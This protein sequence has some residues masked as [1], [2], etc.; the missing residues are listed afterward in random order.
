MFTGFASGAFFALFA[1]A[2]LAQST[3]RIDVT[4]TETGIVV[5]VSDVSL[6]QVLTEMQ[7]KLG[8]QFRQV[9]DLSVHVTAHAEG[10]KL[11]EVLSQLLQNRASFFLKAASQ[12]EKLED[13]EYV[14]VMGA[15]PAATGGQR[16]SGPVVITLDGPSNPPDSVEARMAS[17]KAAV[18]KART[19]KD[20]E[21]IDALSA[22]A[23]SSLQ[24][25]FQQF[26]A[27]RNAQLYSRVGTVHSLAR[28]AETAS[29]L[30][31]GKIIKLE[32]AYKHYQATGDLGPLMR[33]EQERRA[34]DAQQWSIQYELLK[35]QGLLLAPPAPAS[36]D[37]PNP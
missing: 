3:S 23:P 18:E 29:A 32:E 19:Q 36:K 20:K 24:Q 14:V 13:V 15:M 16:P 1:L 34:Q 12:G 37:K 5:D 30:Q 26:Q 31:V 2:A 17:E 10:R 7:N 28:S 27:M 11:A 8:V 21:T 25:S 9:G 22:K 35:A 33:A 4:R 6:S